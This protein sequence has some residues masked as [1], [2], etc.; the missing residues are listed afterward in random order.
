M[1]LKACFYFVNND[2]HVLDTCLLFFYVQQ[3]FAPERTALR[4]QRYPPEQVPFDGVQTYIKAALLNV[5]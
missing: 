3:H 5:T 2:A 1:H 4:N